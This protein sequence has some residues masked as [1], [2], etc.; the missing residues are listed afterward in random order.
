[1]TAAAQ[2]T[3]GVT[4]PNAVTPAADPIREA[5][6][7]RKVADIA[8]MYGWKIAHW[9][10]GWSQRGYRTPARYDGSGFPD[11]V[12]IHPI[13]GLIWYRELKAGDRPNRQLDGA[14]QLWRNWLISAGVNYD[15]WRPDDFDDIVAALSNGKAT[16][17]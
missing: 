6:F 12:L 5:D 15:V 2:D 17:Q 13:R 1:M 3:A 7:E 10:I 4:L 8:R 16:P 11:F 14:Q 9:G